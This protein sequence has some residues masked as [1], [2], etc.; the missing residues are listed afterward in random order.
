[1][2]RTQIYIQCRNGLHLRP[3]TAMCAEAQKYESAI[4]LFFEGKT[5]N[6]KS[7]LSVLACGIKEGA[8]IELRA[9]G[10]DEEKALHATAAV[11][12]RSMNEQEDAQ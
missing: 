8:R 10:P 11:L 5:A 2:V 4:H 9:E 6:A 3:A 1:M 7:V 12:L